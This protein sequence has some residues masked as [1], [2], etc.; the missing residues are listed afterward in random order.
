MPKTTI[1]EEGNFRL[2]PNEIRLAL[3]GPM[4]AVSLQS[5]VPQK[6]HHRHLGS[7]IAKR[8]HRRHDPRTDFS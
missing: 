3:N 1:D 2:Y 8:L 5:I 7:L 4:A 6:I